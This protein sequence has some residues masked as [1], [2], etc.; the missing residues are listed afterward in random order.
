MVG[1]DCFPVEDSVNKF[2][3]FS[4]YFFSDKFG[5]NPCETFPTIAKTKLERHGISRWA[6]PNLDFN[7]HLPQIPGAPGLF[8]CSTDDSDETWTTVIK[9]S[10]GKWLYV[11]EYKYVQVQDLTAE[12]FRAQSQNVC[13]ELLLDTWHAL[14]TGASHGFQVKMTWAKEI[15]AKRQWAH[16]T[17]ARIYLRAH[18]GGRR[19]TIQE[20][21]E[22]IPKVN[23]LT[24]SV[25][26]IL[27]AFNTGQEV[28]FH[29]YH[30][31]CW[32]NSW[33]RPCQW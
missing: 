2:F 28:C 8:F 31:R 25:E 16:A 10:A 17:F 18:N 33:Y 27:D 12:E 1:L 6:F 20:Q 32:T 3:L 26:Q 23:T 30:A 9:L 29:A 15:C 21:L 19:P 7:P 11:G 14:I 4:R 5:G 13:V 22:T 24:L